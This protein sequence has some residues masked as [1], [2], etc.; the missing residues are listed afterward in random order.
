M[1]NE[2]RGCSFPSDS[3]TLTMAAARQSPVN[4][5]SGGCQFFYAG[6]RALLARRYVYTEAWGFARMPQVVR[7][8]RPMAQSLTPLEQG[9]S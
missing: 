5:R 8:R 6:C 3:D 1:R 7:L 2:H 4:T 9:G